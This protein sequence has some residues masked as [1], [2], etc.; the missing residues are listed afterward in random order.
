MYRIAAKTI[1]YNIYVIESNARIMKQNV[2]RYM[3]DDKEQLNVSQEDSEPLP[4][5]W[6]GYTMVNIPYPHL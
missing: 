1:I 5:M 2:N 3:N 6:H 4:L